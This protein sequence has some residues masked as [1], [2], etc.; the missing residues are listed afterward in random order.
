MT[1]LKR[2]SG[3]ANCRHG[4]GGETFHLDMGE[5]VRIVDWRKTNSPF[6]A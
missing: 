3:A 2:L 5:Q 6:R 1:I 4:Q